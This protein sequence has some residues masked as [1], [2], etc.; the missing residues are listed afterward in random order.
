MFKGCR[1]KFSLALAAGLLAAPPASVGFGQG[2]MGRPAGIDET[3]KS[4][5]V[6]RYQ[7]T[8]EDD[9]R[10][11]RV[12]V[13][14]KVVFADDYSDVR[15]LAGDAR[16]IVEDARKGEPERRYHVERGAGGGLA[17]YYWVD[18]A[19]REL[20]AEGREWVGRTLLE[21]VRR[22]GLNA[23]ERARSILRRGGPRALSA[24]IAHLRGDHTLR[25][26][27]EELLGA[28]GLGD[29]A[30]ADALRAASRVTAD[31]ER[32][33]LLVRTA[34]SFLS[35]ERLVPAY[36]EAAARIRSDYEL[37][38][39]LSN[40]VSREGLG[41]AALAAA[42]RAAAR[43][44]SDYEKATFLIQVAR[45]GAGDERVRAAFAEVLG[46]ISSVYERA[47]VERV[48]ARR[49]PPN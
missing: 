38:R 36:F 30:L 49:A 48:S 43:I 7:W 34:D 18:G 6:S 21:A 46:T 3:K 39:V 42:V 33:Q 9:D 35:R 15:E 40:A 45:L 27:F 16:L 5:S 41:P 20:D 11:V 12:T 1:F 25:I 14:N 4:E 13:D 47:R 37:R 8:Q 17:R 26:Y 23:R 10:R 24:E 2:P 29:D 22:G 32:A 31:Y 44:G 19:E 28:P